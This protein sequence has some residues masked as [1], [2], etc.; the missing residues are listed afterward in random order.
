MAIMYPIYKRWIDLMINGDILDCRDRDS[1][2]GRLCKFKKDFEFRTRLPKALKTGD[3]VYIYEPVKHGGS[4]KVVA[5]FTVGN[6]MK[7]DY[8]FGAYPF[9]VHFCRDIL[10]NED[11]AKKFERAVSVDLTQYK[12]GFAMKY[13]LDDESVDCIEKTG[14]IPDIITYLYD[15][16]RFKNIDESERVWKWTDEYLTRIGLYNDFG[17]SNYKF[18]IEVLNPI[19]YE[20]PKNLSNFRKLDDSVVGKPPQSFVYVQEIQ[21]VETKKGLE[22]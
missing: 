12:T 16:F 13:A 17:E 19:Q 22:I 11:Y 4:G 10:K 2:A 15:R 8:P 18:A 21:Q 3:K 5:E 20:T 14:D 6:I 9:I 7:C 1:D